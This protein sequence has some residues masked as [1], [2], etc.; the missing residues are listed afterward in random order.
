LTKTPIFGI[1]ATLGAA[2]A[3]WL[4]TPHGRVDTPAFMPVGTQGAVKALLPG[5]LEAAGVQM[6][7]GNAYHLHLRP[8]EQVVARL[9]GLHRFMGWSRALLTD[10]GGFQVFS[11]AELRR[12]TDQ[13]VEFRSHIDGAPLVLTPERATEIQNAL[14]ADVIMA[15][16]ECAAYP[17]ERDAAEVAMRRTVA[18]ARRCQ[19]AHAR[20]ADQALFAIVQGSV[21]DDLRAECAARLV[22]MDFPGYAVGGVS[23]GEGDELMYRVL[24]ATLPRLPAAKPRYL[25]GVGTPVNLLECIERGVDMFD[26]VLPTR[27]ARSGHAFTAGGIVRLRNR[28]HRDDPGP[29]D[30]TCGCATCRGFSRGYL[31]HLFHAREIAAAVLVS[32]HNV[33]FYQ[34]LVHGCRQAIVEGRFD[35]FKRAF[36]EQFT[37]PEDTPKP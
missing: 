29:L 3:G 21:F 17:C 15:F 31:R 13:G 20:P 16:D 24:D 10:S 22:D 18:W 2:R 37:Q 14:G 26:C 23:V 7:L 6:L 32:L 28:R 35:A 30:P 25:M 9:G 5:Q 34:R 4:A 33:A 12:V 1:D 8:G 36:L 11:L 19:K 27:N